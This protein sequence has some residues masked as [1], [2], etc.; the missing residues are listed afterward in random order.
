MFR[1]SWKL[2]HPRSQNDGCPKTAASIADPGGPKMAVQQWPGKGLMGVQ[3]I[4]INGM[5]GA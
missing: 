4:S 2:G 3:F 1:K 5:M